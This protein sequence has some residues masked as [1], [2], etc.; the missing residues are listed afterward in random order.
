[1]LKK[2]MLI[3]ALAASLIGCDRSPRPVLLQQRVVEARAKRT[4]EKDRPFSNGTTN[5]TVFITGLVSLGG[6][7]SSTTPTPKTLYLIDAT[8]PGGGLM[9]H[10]PIVMT[11]VVY[12]PAVPKGGRTL[13]SEGRVARYVRLANG[14]ELSFKE[15]A[16][17]PLSYSQDPPAGTCPTGTERDSLYFIPR[18]SWVGL[19]A[20]GKPL[21]SADY[22]PAF[23]NPQAG[24]PVVASFPINYG[25]L[26]SELQ[27]PLVWDFKDGAKG[28]KITA[29]QVLADKILWKF[30]ILGDTLTLQSNNSELL[31]MKAVGGRIILTIA[32]APDPD[33]IQILAGTALNLN[34]KKQPLDDHF[35]LYYRFLQN[36]SLTPFRP[37]AQGVCLNGSVVI[38]QCALADFIDIPKPSSCPPLL[39]GQPAPP[40]VGGINCGPD[41]MP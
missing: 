15:A 39:Q 11:D 20:D 10:A 1:L 34:P 5:V 31:K 25:Q 27:T 21:S 19:K 16:L 32:N 36:K 14:E 12:T 17:N 41:G 23:L 18:L 37:V 4:H 24:G 8:S 40:L 2:I 26:M 22:D 6:F 30:V 28:A 29:N 9:A 35:A 33:G 7:D 13:F 38:D 3:S